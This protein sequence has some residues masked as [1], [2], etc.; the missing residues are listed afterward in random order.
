MLLR[1]QSSI[2]LVIPNTTD[3]EIA[4]DKARKTSNSLGKYFRKDL[5]HLLC[6]FLL[7]SLAFPVGYVSVL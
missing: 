1:V 5:L 3:C 6:V 4:L 7:P 2:S